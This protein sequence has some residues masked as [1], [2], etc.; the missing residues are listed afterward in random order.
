MEICVDKNKQ[1]KGLFVQDKQMGKAFE[2][3]AELVCLDAT[4]KLLNLGLPVFLML[5]E[6]LSGQSEIIALSMIASEDTTSVRW[7]LATFKKLNPTWTNIRV[8]MADKDLKERDVIKDELPNESILI[9]LFN[10]FRTFRREITCDKMGITA[11][12]RVTC[13]EWIQKLA[14]SS[15]EDE[16]NKLHKDLQSNCPKNVVEYFNHNWHPLKGE[17]VLGLKAECGSFLNMTN[18]RLECING[19]LKQVINHHSSLQEFID[20]FFIILQSLRTERDHKAALTF[21]KTKVFLFSENSDERRY[22]QLL[23]SYASSFV[24]K[25]LKL[26]D[27]VKEIQRKDEKYVVETNDGIKT[28]SECSC[29]CVFHKS[30]KLPC[31]H[32]FSLRKRLGIPLFD[33]SICDK[34]WTSEYYHSTQRLFSEFSLQ[35]SVAITMIEKPP[36]RLS[37]HEKFKKANVCT[38]ELAAVISEASHVNFYRRLEMVQNLCEYWKSG[39]EVGLKLIDEGLYLCNHLAV[40]LYVSVHS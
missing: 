35:P 34:R 21:H 38:T 15:S 1:F 25:Q 28:V 32:M 4:Y 30:M 31:R 24:V 23:T 20:K 18:N 10:T 36:R 13:V 2:A 9:C 19:K 39:K 37:Q 7:M 17:W 29:E 11:G 6:D 16:Y 12:Q 22:C 33:A 5:C 3:Y 14:Y 8:V 27:K 40:I 26:V